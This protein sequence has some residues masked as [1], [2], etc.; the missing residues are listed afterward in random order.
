MADS[1]EKEERSQPPS[2][3]K[4]GNSEVEENIG[5]TSSTESNLGK[6]GEHEEGPNSIAKESDIKKLEE[7][8]KLEQKKSQDL[9]S[10]MRYLQ[11]DIINLQ[12][13]N[14]KMLVDVRNQARFA[15]L[16]ELI[17]VKEDLE[18][19]LGASST[20]QQE[21]LVEGLKLLRSRIESTLRSEDV[22]DIAP[23]PGDRLDPRLHEAVLSRSTPDF[24][25]GTIVSVI[26]HGYV[27]A[28]KVVRPAL[29]EVAT[30]SIEKPEN[31]I[32]ATEEALME[33]KE[34]KKSSSDSP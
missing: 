23:K 17:S 15:L 29:V 10:R 30:Q 24:E 4:K 20:P 2:G 6:K 7:E 33:T 34:Q 21:S 27:I 18:R 9:A 5:P 32:T 25:S 8:L 13:Q 1:T 3:Q 14:D 12:K 26:R 19:A 16:L 28:G 11:A 31:P 22:S